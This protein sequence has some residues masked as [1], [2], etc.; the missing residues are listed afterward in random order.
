MQLTVESKTITLVA[1]APIV[2][3]ATAESLVGP[4]SQVAGV[5]TGAL[6]E[7][8][9]TANG[10]FVRF[11]DGTQICWRSGLN[12]TNVGTAIGAIFRNS[13]NPTWTFPAP[14]IAPPVVHA[15]TD[16]ADAWAKVAAAPTATAAVLR[17]FSATQIV[18][19]VTLRAMAIGRW[20]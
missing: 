2:V 4:V 18:T 15:D 16:S 7:R 20:F 9:A 10:E 19:V 1:A 17:A 5:P 3:E 8:G 14:F 6:I 13:T 11:A 12:V